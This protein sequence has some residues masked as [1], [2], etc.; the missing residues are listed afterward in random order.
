MQYDFVK[1]GEYTTVSCP[2]SDA[3]ELNKSMAANGWQRVWSTPRI[4]TVPGFWEAYQESVDLVDDPYQGG[5][6]DKHLAEQADFRQF[7]AKDW[8]EGFE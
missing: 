5:K 2:M 1:Y 8:E 4:I 3:P 7:T 6:P